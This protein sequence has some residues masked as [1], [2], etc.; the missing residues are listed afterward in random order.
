M[1]FIVAGGGLFQWRV[2]PFGLHSAPATFQRALDSVI[3]PELEPFAFAYLD[4]IIVIG[5]TLDEHLANLQ[6]VFHRLRSANLR[7]NSDKCQFF[8]KET[9]YLGHV[10]CGAGIQT[11]PDKVTAIMEMKPPENVKELPRRGVLVPP[12]RPGARHLG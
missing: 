11:D 4:D 8:Q 6:E 9:K 5:R 10:V 2:M 1:A 12:F 3:G 7:I